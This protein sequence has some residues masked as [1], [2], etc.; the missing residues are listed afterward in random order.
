[1]ENIL[2]ESL[3]LSKTNVP[4]KEANMPGGNEEQPPE[5]S[6]DPEECSPEKGKDK[7]VEEK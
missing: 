3:T 1:M 5:G 6:I 4:T 7:D 2:V